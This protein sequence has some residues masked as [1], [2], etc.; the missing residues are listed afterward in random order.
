[1]RPGG[2]IFDGSDSMYRTQQAVVKRAGH[3]VWL[4]EF[5]P[6]R[7]EHLGFVNR[8]M[9]TLCE[10]DIC[11]A[12]VNAYP[13]FIAGVTS[14]YSLGGNVISLLNIARTECPTL[15][16]FNGKVPSFQVGPFTFSLTVLDQY[17]NYSE[18]R[19]YSLFTVSQGDEAVQLLVGVVDSVTC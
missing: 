12:I 9:Q 15:D 4:N 5:S 13:A 19:D 14:V 2:R 10:L 6:A 18:Y 17:A 3:A 11:C 7:L 8:L 1:M 16:N